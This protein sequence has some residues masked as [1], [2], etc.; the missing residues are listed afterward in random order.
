MRIV[1]D[2]CVCPPRMVIDLIGVLRLC[3]SGYGCA[4]GI[5]LKEDGVLGN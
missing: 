2:D 1:R 4:Y 3:V 5:G